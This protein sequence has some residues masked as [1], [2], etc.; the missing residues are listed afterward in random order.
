M[1]QSASPLVILLTCLLVALVM[2]FPASLIATS[3]TNM[4][5]YLRCGTVSSPLVAKQV[6]PK[7]E[8]FPTPCNVTKVSFVTSCV[9]PEYSSVSGRIGTARKYSQ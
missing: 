2:V 4:S 7:R 9:G 5:G 8:V 3:A 6:F 1:F